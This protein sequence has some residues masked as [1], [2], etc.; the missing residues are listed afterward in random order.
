[1]LDLGRVEE[2]G[3]DAGGALR[4]ANAPRSPRRSARC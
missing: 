2:F 3:V 1:V 4:A